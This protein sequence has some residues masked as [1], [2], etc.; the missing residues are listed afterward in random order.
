MDE[1]R[2]MAVA[3]HL[4][5]PLVGQEQSR[6]IPSP[7]LEHHNAASGQLR[8]RFGERNT[9]I[10][11]PTGL[12]TIGHARQGLRNAFT[13]RLVLLGHGNAVAIVPHRHAEGHPHDRGRVHGLPEHALR[14]GGVSN[15][16]ERHF[17][18]AV[19]QGLGLEAGLLH[20]LA[21]TP[22]MAAGVGQTQE[23]RHL[24]RGRR[25]VHRAVRPGGQ[26]QELPIGAHRRRAEVAV[27]L[28]AR[29][30]G[31]P[32][33]VGVGVQLGEVLLDGEQSQRHHQGLVP[34][35]STAE[36]ARPE[37]AREG[38]LGHLFSIAENAK[39][40]L[41][42]QDLLPS[43]QGSFTADAGELI[44]VEGH[45]AEVLTSVERESLSHG[46]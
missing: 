29:G 8:F 3:A 39:L 14:G 46:R 44:I 15:G 25:Q 26:V 43:K 21:L 16:A 22:E 31:L 10:P 32:F 37:L 28:A 42:R 7:D 41:A 13:R 2:N 12:G 1:H 5:G 11:C 9:P 27:H 24:A 30:H 6:V 17:P 19:R 20:R 38:Q 36:V 18:S 23:P 40:G 45:L 4:H 34:V 35:V 33:G